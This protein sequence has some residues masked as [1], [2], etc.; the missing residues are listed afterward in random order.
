MFARLFTWA[1]TQPTRFD[2]HTELSQI[3]SIIAELAC[4][5]ANLK[6]IAEK[7]GVDSLAYKKHIILQSLLKDL[8]DIITAFNSHP[9]NANEAEEVGSVIATVQ[10][11][12]EP[13]LGVIREYGDTLA[14]KRNVNKDLARLGAGIGSFSLPI[15]A[16]V[17]FALP[18]LLTFLGTMYFTGQVGNFVV[19]SD[20]FNGGAASQEI[21][22]RLLV[23]L[24]S[25]RDNL[26]LKLDL[27]R[28]D[29]VEILL[30]SNSPLECMITCEL[31]KD[32]VFCALDGQTYE[33]EAITKWLTEHRTSPHNR[34]K[35]EVPDGVNVETAV[36]IA[37]MPNYAVMTMIE[38]ARKDSAANSNNHSD[39]G[40]DAVSMNPAA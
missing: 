20:K 3:T 32:A 6:M 37:L 21:V 14:L 29:N 39:A 16:G 19:E 2:R 18:A 10:A 8:S 5:D 38:N 36:E 40:K 7:E 13:V 33:R 9:A 11:L 15:A 4:K 17:Y 31:M 12:I 34:K 1:K 26:K 25:I 28:D 30:E 24:R 23:C 22:N 35:L 27:E